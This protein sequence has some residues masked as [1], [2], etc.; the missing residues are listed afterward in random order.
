[1]GA[2]E[3]PDHE[4][5]EDGTITCPP[6]Y[7]STL[8]TASDFSAR[9]QSALLRE[10]TSILDEPISEEQTDSDKQEETSKLMSESEKQREEEQEKE[11]DKEQENENQHEKKKKK[12]KK[13]K[14]TLR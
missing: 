4:K 12:K 3:E 11:K 9:L 14:S 7:S 6:H 8:R 5:L 2:R 1:M 10:S 13:K